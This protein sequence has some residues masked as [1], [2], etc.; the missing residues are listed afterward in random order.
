VG[1]IRYRAVR[2]AVTGSSGFIGGELVRSLRADG[3]DVV[4]VVRSDDGAAGTARWDIDAGEIDAAALE[5]LDGVVHLAGEGIG[6]KRW[7]RDQKRRILESRT[8]GTTLLATTLAGLDAPPRVLVSGSAI[9][10]YGDRG[11]EELDEESAPGTG[12]L[13]EVAQQWEASTAP[14][15]A[16]GVRVA[17]LRTGIV[18]APKGGVLAKFLP[19]FKFGVGGRF[20]PGTQWM[21]WI[22]LDDEVSAIMH[23]LTSD[24]TGAVNLTAPAP[25]TNAELAD[26]LGDV[27]HRPTILPVPA[28]GPRLLLG[29]ERANGLLFE[30]QRVLPR[31]LQGDGFVHAH[32]TLSDCLHAILGR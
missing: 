6:D 30:G 1:P 9:G 25:V 12:F 31:V 26:T 16:A 2:V 8:R 21:S 24:V 10:Y 17:H 13:S 7:T 29:G 28:F 27:L 14:A 11:D 5:G 23:L 22:S 4:R 20:G 32:P 3:H 15:A 19:L 18:L